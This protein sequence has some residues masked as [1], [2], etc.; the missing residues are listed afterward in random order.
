MK[1]LLV[2]LG[3]LSLLSAAPNATVYVCDSGK[4][5]AYHSEKSCRGLNRCTHQ[6]VSVNESDAISAYRLRKCKICY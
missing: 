1:K 3:L 6:I 2:G 4:E 5:I